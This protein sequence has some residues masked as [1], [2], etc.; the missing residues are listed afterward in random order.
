MTD[1]PLWTILPFLGLTFL[2]SLTG[3]LF[4]P[5]PWYDALR[6]PAW[7]PPNWLFP[8]VWGLLYVLMAYAA[9]R[10]WDVAGIGPALGLWGLQLVLNAGWSAVFFGLRRPGLAL[11]EVA[12]LWLAVAATL[13]AFMEIDLIAG[14]V[15][16]PYLTWVTIASVLNAEIVR[17][18]RTPA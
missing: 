3:A 4:R 14:A 9:W 6:K 5:V 15:M 8:V 12:G 18:R 2:A 10:V 11:L 1:A 7:T 17:L 13:A 16:A